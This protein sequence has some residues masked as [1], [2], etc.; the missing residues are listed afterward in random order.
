MPYLSAAVF[1]EKVLQER[2]GV[3]SAIRIVDRFQFSGTE[4]EMAPKTLNA[5]LLLIFKSGFFRGKLSIKLSPKSPSGK[6][7]PELE[8]PALFEGDD[9]GVGIVAAMG[10]VAQEEGL[11]WFDVLLQE[12]L[13]TRIP[14]RVLYHTLTRSGSPEP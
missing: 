10:F 6:Q 5:T 4:K 14:L 11:Y 8:F 12:Q 2:D 1:C 9:R 7:L 13:I 3:M